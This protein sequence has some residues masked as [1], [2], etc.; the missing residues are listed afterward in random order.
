VELRS[1]VA[2]ARQE[3]SLRAWKGRTV[4]EVPWYGLDPDMLGAAGITDILSMSDTRSQR[5]SDQ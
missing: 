2:C 3:T 1:G 4:C 5:T